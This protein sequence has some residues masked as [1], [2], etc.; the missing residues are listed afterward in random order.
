MKISVTRLVKRF[1][2][3]L[4]FCLVQLE[5]AIKLL[6]GIFASCLMAEFFYYERVFSYRLL[7]FLLRIAF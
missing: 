5:A 3:G 6:A 4:S 1:S 7:F 2:I